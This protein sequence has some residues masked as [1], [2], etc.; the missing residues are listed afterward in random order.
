[1]YNLQAKAET[2]PLT[3]YTIYTG[4]FYDDIKENP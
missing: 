4:D 2:D 1:L 3:G